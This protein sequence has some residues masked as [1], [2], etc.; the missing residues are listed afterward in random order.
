MP[1]RSTCGRRAEAPTRPAEGAAG[2]DA[3]EA[4]TAAPR[5]RADRDAD[6]RRPTYRRSATAVTLEIDVLTLFPAMIEGPLAREHPRPDPG[7]GPR[8][9]P[10][11]RPARLGPRAPSLAST[12]RPYGG[13][14]GM[15]L[16]PEPVAAALDA[17]RRPDSTVILLDP[18][19]EVFRQARAADLA[20]AVAPR[21][22]LPA[23]RGR[24]RADPL[25]GRPGALDR[26]LRADRRRAAR[27]RRHRRGHPPAARARSRRPPRPRNPS[28]PACWSTRSTRG[29]RP[30]AAWTCRPILTSGDHGAV[31]RWRHEQA[32][33]RTPAR[34]PDLLGDAG[35]PDRRRAAAAT[36]EAA[37]RT[38]RPSRPA[39]AILR[40][41]RTRRAAPGP[42]PPQPR[43][44]T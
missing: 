36:A 25:A 26:R 7:A 10:G 6:R 38:G 30:S 31:D 3:S 32:L 27:A 33:E 12:T 37:P 9:D 16:R 20:D 14:A 42:S 1:R 5:R 18:G 29:R 15:V 34:R 4:A 24:R 13:G 39:R 41:R 2:A 19:G 8:D 35:Q 28:P 21:L 11:P 40:R 43:L 23:L 44:P 17:L 22:R